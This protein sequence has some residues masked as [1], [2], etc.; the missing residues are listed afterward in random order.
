MRSFRIVFLL[1]LLAGNSY[2][3]AGREKHFIPYYNKVNLAEQQFVN[4]QVRECL[5]TYDKVFKEYSQPFVTDCYIAAQIAYSAGDTTRF[6]NYLGLV[7]K[8][9][10]PITALDAAPMLRNVTGNKPLYN[11]IQQQFYTKS[12]LF[13]VDTVAIDS[14]QMMGFAADSFKREFEKSML[15]NETLVASFT[16][17]EETFRQYVYNKYISRGIFPLEKIT[18]IRTDSTFDNFV[19]KY[20]KAELWPKDNTTGVPEGMTVT[21]LAKTEWLLSNTL[22]F[23]I[24]IHSTCTINEYGPSLWQ[25]VLN[26]YMHPKDYGMLEEMCISWNRKGTFA[27]HARIC[28]YEKKQAY[29]NILGYSPLKTINTFTNEALLK[30]VE[31]NRADHFMQKYSVDVEKKRLEK[32][33]GFKFFFGFG[34]TR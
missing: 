3:S 17:E 6:L 26:G 16:K 30:A 10:M 23:N 27:K 19:L 28:D 32:E 24:F 7:F 15:K 18:G 31:K 5:S 8:N 9:G 11:R 33:K 34:N 4:N 2:Y 29:Y 14:M 12:K 21:G 13:K 1:A 25:C 22:G 20:N